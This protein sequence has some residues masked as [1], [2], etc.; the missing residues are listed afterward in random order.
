[1]GKMIVVEGADGAGKGTQVKLLY[2]RLVVKGAKVE[3]FDF[4][5]YHKSTGK[6]VGEVLAG[7][8]G[9]FLQTSPYL[10]A[11]PYMLDRAA[12]RDELN[13][14]LA[15]SDVVLC[16]RYIPS[17]LAYGS[18]KLPEPHERIAYTRFVEDIEYGEL[19]MPKPDMVVYLAVSVDVARALIMKKA[20]R[21]YLDGQAQ[22]QHEADIAYQAKVAACYREIAS[23]NERWRIIECVCDGIL[24]APDDVH[25]LVWQ[26]LA[27]M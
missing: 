20:A 5:R 1:M 3:I 7:K 26:E 25:A 24:L 21:E 18:A 11:I 9:D 4:P 14:A 2:D 10:A 13:A 22:D 8:H 19:R 16:N 17:N 12:A 15:E 27:V 23:Q 6:L